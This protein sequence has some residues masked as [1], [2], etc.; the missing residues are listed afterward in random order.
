MLGKQIPASNCLGKVMKEYRMFGFYGSVLSKWAS[1]QRGFGLVPAAGAYL[2]CMAHVAIPTGSRAAESFSWG[3]VVMGGGGFV[4][5]II[6][7]KTEKNVIY[8][9]TDVGGAYRWN[10]ASQGWIP[11]TDW[12]GPND[13]GLLGID[14]LAIDPSTPG[15]LYMLAGTDYWNQGKT[16]ILRSS[17]YGDTFDTV[18][19]TAQFKTHGNGYGRQNGE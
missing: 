13:M 14:G 7:S 8:A 18:N 6:A 4:S 1:I 5:G 19:V 11:I 15:R 9:R 2:F 3:T 17:D 10:E 16:M 12:L